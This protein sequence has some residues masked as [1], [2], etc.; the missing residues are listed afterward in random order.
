[1][2][3]AEVKRWALA[4]DLLD[5]VLEQPPGQR[6]EAARELG[7]K[8]QCL[9]E[10]VQLLA[11]AVNESLLD[12][13]LHSLISELPDPAPGVNEY[14]GQ[15]IGN[16]RLGEEIGRGGMSV[17][18]HAE[19]V[20]QDFEQRA[21][22]KILSVGH[23]DDSFVE[24]FLRERQILS[25]LQHPGIARLIDGGITPAGAP[26]LVMQYVEGQAINEWCSAQNADVKTI[27]SLMIQ[28]CDAVAYQQKHL[29]VHQD[30]NPANV[31][32]NEHGNPVVIDFGIASLVGPASGSGSV[33]AF[34]P[35]FSAP[36]QRE[37]G[38]ITTATDVYALGKLFSLL[39]SDRQP[40]SELSAVITAATREDPEQRYVNARQLAN[41]LIAW[42][43]KRPLQARANTRAYRFKRFV[44][45]NRL[46]FTATS[47]VVISVLGGLGMSIWQ[48]RIAAAERD[49]AR[50]ESQ[51]ANQVTGFLTDLFMAS[52][53][54]RSMGEPLTAR[55]LLDQGAHQARTAFSEVPG[56]KA[57]MLVLVGNLYN[58]LGEMQSA[59]DVLSE[60]LAVAESVNEPG[61]VVDALTALAKARMEQGT[62]AGALELVARAEQIL[63]DE[64]L[65]PGE[66]H[67]RLMH[68]WLFSLTESGQVT[69][70]VE[71]GQAALADARLKTSLTPSAMF[72]YL[73]N[74]A[75]ALLVAAQPN[76]AKPLLL[77]A[78]ELDI[79]AADDP[80]VQ[81]GLHTSLASLYTRDGNLTEALE[82]DQA[83]VELAETIYAP[84]HSERARKLSNLGSTLSQLDRQ[85]EAE[86]ALLESISIM[87]TLYPGRAHPRVASAYNNL[88][89]M[90]RRSGDYEA[91]LPYA[92]QTLVLA[93]QLF[94]REDPRFA[95]STGNLGDLLRRMGNLERAEPLLLEN[96]ALRQ[97]ILG[98]DHPGVGNGLSLLAQLRLDQDQYREALERASDALEM[99]ER[100]EYDHPG[101]LIVTTS[102][103][104]QALAGLGRTAEARATFEQAFSMADA[105]GED[106]VAIVS[107][108]Q[109]AFDAFESGG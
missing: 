49:V 100:I 63:L 68:P 59:N 14:Q 42:R 94:G 37:G 96:L 18:Y 104:A 87:E 78:I 75:N 1:M 84:I 36:E 50:L 65:V 10:I 101:A 12:G 80:S 83:A 52:D 33:K 13:T 71:R 108:L 30:I 55:K 102:R 44:D 106:A 74:L 39:V 69:E 60:A 109:K 2:D 34:T 19:R 4:A 92:E 86:A 3:Q 82:H 62:H 22:L 85:E 77:K 15:L 5:K 7:K 41:D 57:E 8:H 9:D 76:E 58:E 47:L 64:G 27:T 79:D 16:W 103:K 26:Y 61:L 88:A 23:L 93:E 97:S 29:V 35:G 66:Q 53:P 90:W 99:F 6:S 73:Y 107:D 89:S 56:L 72:E 46:G 67:A 70:A 43:E 25:D 54:D 24:G 31:L 32:V 48:A 17:V 20:G 81:I 11:G 21:A 105:S 51:R 38:A 98:P 91:A 40:D 95:I 28:L 45:R